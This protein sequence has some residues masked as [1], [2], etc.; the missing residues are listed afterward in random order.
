MVFKIDSMTYGSIVLSTCGK[1]TDH[2][3]SHVGQN[4]PCDQKVKKREFER[5]G[6]ESHYPL[7]HANIVK[8]PPFSQSGNKLLTHGP[9]GSIEDPNHSP[10]KAAV[11][12]GTHTTISERHVLS[13]RSQLW[14]IRVIQ[15]IR[16]YR[17]QLRRD[18][19]HDGGDCQDWGEERWI[20]LESLFCTTKSPEDA[21][22]C[23]HTTMLFTFYHR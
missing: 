3:R 16:L 10:C 9:F 11:K 19:K 23:G 8:V 17:S 12:M 20:G 4:I 15:F 14:E 2:G 5:K 18:G 21:D 13:E 1:A 22:G 7:D 6:L